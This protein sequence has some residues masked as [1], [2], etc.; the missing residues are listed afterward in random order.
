MGNLMRA[1]SLSV[2]LGCIFAAS[3]PASA[4]GSVDFVVNGPGDYDYAQQIDIP[5]GFGEGEFTLELWIRPNNSFSVGTVEGDVFQRENWADDDEVPYSTSTWWYKGNFLLDGHN[6]GTGFALGTFSLQFYGGGRVRWLFGDGS[7]AIPVGDVWSAGAYPATN[8][9][10]LL[11]GAWHQVTLIRRWAGQSDAQ[12][13]IWIDGTLI[14]TETSDVRTDMRQWWTG[15]AGFPAAQQGWFWGVEKQAAV[16]ILDQYEDYKGLV[17]ELRFWSRAKSAS[18]VMSGFMSAVT[19]TEPG[20]VGNYSF[21]E[22]QGNQICDLQLPSRCMTLVNASANVWSSDN[23]PVSAGSDTAS[24]TVPS[25]LQGSAVS[26]TQVD[27]SWNASTD[28]VAVTAYDVRRDGMIVGSPAGTTFSDGGLTANT[29]YTYTVSAR[30]AAGNVS[31]QSAPVMVTTRAT[32]DTTPPTVPTNLQG[33]AASTSQ[34]DLAWDASSDNVAVVAYDVRRDGNLI[35]SPGGT[36]FSDTGLTTGTTYAYTISARDA[37]GNA[38]GETSAIMVATLSQPDV[39]APTTP[40]DVQGSA[41]SP[42]QIDLSWTASTDNVS[43]AAYDVSRDGVIVASPTGTSFSDAGLS[44]NTSYTYTITARDAS[45]NASQASSPVMIATLASPDT[46]PPTTPQGLQGSA[47]SSSQI[48]LTWSASSDNVGVTSYEITRNGVVVGSSTS[49]AYTDSGLAASTQ[50]TYTVSAIDLAGNESPGSAS[51]NVTTSA[52][53]PGPS[54]PPPS[55]GGGGGGGGAFG[56]N[57]LLL[58]LACLCLRRRFTPKPM[59]R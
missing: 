16:G 53:N 18:E 58:G 25:N 20:L 2:F 50:Y 7:F 22:G 57:L 13:E 14:D 10:S 12:L 37:A 4:Q 59:C 55:G 43:V 5:L 36:S 31:G 39:Q 49:A 35:A 11:D 56:M 6:N 27:L 46:E 45:N 40:T 42:T 8:A 3:S 17:D 1:I 44:A 52:A 21:G 19:G 54:A 51:I 15:W 9:P 29:S 32:A 34:I 33:S 26:T 47:A 23:A 41:V 38:S 24:P 30:D 48:N 28:N